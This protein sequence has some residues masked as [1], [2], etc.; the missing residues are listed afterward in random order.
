MNIIDS[1]LNK[2]K[3]TQIELRKHH[4]LVTFIKTYYQE[5]VYS[6]QAIII[7]IFIIILQL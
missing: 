4:D 5:R 2:C 3:I 1:T 7:Y 6:F